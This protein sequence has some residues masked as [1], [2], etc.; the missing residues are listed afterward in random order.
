MKK[1]KV[2]LV[3]VPVFLFLV[4]LI[5]VLFLSFKWKNKSQEHLSS[6]LEKVDES[7]SQGYYLR[8]KDLL[9]HGVN[10]AYSKAELMRVLK[11][12]F[13]LYVNTDDRDFIAEIC[14]KAWENVQT[15]EIGYLYVYSLINL[16]RYSKALDI[17]ERVKSF[18]DKYNSNIGDLLAI[19][20]MLKT[21]YKLQ[22]EFK[23]EEVSN[24]YKAIT[25]PNLVSPEQLELLGRKYG[26]EILVNSVLAWAREG[27]IKRAYNLLRE[28][29]EKERG[30]KE[31]QIYLSYDIGDFKSTLSY[32]DAYLT[33]VNPNKLD[34][35]LL[36][37][38]VFLK[39]G[40]MD[41]AQIIYRG[42]IRDFP[43]FSWTPY[44][45][46]G[47]I[48]EL[49][50]KIGSAVKILEKGVYYFPDV[51]PLSLYLINL[52]V[53]NGKLKNAKLFLNKCVER[54]HD[55]N[56]FALLDLKLNVSRFS[57][58][59]YTAE[60]WKLYNDDPGNAN[61]AQYLFAYQYELGN[62]KSAKGVLNRFSKFTGMNEL[63]WL[64]HYSGILY[65]VNGNL[66]K[67]EELLKQSVDKD[68]NW[69][70]K[71]NLAVFYTQTKKYDLA[72]EEWDRVLAVLRDRNLSGNGDCDKGIISKIR[73]YKAEIFY[74]TGKYSL[75]KKELQ[76]SLEYDKGNT[77]SILLMKKLNLED[78]MK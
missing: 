10:A 67:A 33:N 49:R 60:L 48:S 61:I 29:P 47:K 41:E 4:I 51:K 54:F 59:R 9:L 37:G 24:L 70:F 19:I 26:N 25:N 44:Y 77:M 62:Y 1:K 32:I 22:S 66:V 65:A 53:K 71:Y 11:R 27:N 12:G 17:L 31:L 15:P 56:D 34:F 57:P 42:I 78:N 72:L 21:D 7:L 23:D 63:P 43:K 13:L 35:K 6:I 2:L 20:L 73:F 18:S 68:S 40:E 28:I 39:L 30:V 74:E 46:M 8:A 3:G 58:P 75:A 69:Y 14:S 38:D 45:N 36:R 50:G 76:I 5:L 52:Y 16:H 55:D 64:L